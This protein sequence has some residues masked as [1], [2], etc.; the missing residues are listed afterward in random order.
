MALITK[1]GT[2]SLA[3][4]LPCAASQ[5]GSGLL[6]GEAIAAGDAC[7]IKGSDGKV[8]RSNGTADNEAAHCDGFAAKAAAVGEAVTL[9]TDVE[10]HYGAGLTPGVAYYVGATAGRLDSAATTGGRT[11]VAFA[12]TATRIRVKADRAQSDAVFTQGAAVADMGA[13]TV[14]ADLGAFTDPPSAAEMALLRTFVNALKADVVAN[15]AKINALLDS[16]QA[17]AIIAP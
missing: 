15:R 11:P 3:T 2:P 14:G 10:F 8:W 7:Y 13:V 5:V 9:Y 1:S 6:A 4:A 12:V 17:A 16:L